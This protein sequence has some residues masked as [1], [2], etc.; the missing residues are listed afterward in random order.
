MHFWDIKIECQLYDFVIHSNAQ[1]FCGKRFPSRAALLGTLT[2]LWVRQPRLP[3][4]N[5]WSYINLSWLRLVMFGRCG[6]VRT[7]GPNRRSLGRCFLTFNREKTDQTWSA[8]VAPVARA[9][10]KTAYATPLT[11]RSEGSSVI[12]SRKS[13]THVEQLELHLEEGSRKFDAVKCHLTLLKH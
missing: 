9:L 2:L 12:A 7:G 5:E 10:Y 4:R 11:L 6:T 1:W 3:K 13:K 8:G